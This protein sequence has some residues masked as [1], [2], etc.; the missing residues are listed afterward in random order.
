MAGEIT[1]LEGVVGDGRLDRALADALPDISRA[2]I[3][4]LAV[5][6]YLE[7][8]D[9][10]IA[11][12]SSKRYAG[13]KFTLRIPPARPDRAVAEDIAIEIV[14]ED[15]DLIIV[16]KPAGMVVH[17]SAG[18][19]SG[20]LVNALLHHCSGQ[21]SGIGG[22]AR[23]GI[24]HRIDRD[25]S[26]L[27]V[28]AKTD[29]A[30]AGLTKLFA[31]HDIERKYLAITRGIPAPPTGR[32]ETHIG[33]SPYDRKKM[34]VVAAP[35]GKHAV[36]HYRMIEP[37]KNAALIE[38]A[39]E[40]GRTHQIRVHLTHMKHPLIGDP[41]YG[42]RQNSIQIGPN[43]SKFARQALHAAILGFIHPVSGKKIRFESN[44]SGDMQELLSK[45]RV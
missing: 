33:R 21:L 17:P 4:A 34:A 14:Y 31:A 1:I 41:V 39:L 32:I 28:A 10:K 19:S 45:L 2:R 13:Q 7:I 42:S 35:D 29:L 26:G 6:G 43:Q 18:H 5:E 15:N 44:L 25:T 38:C 37:L 23:P 24:V 8:G 22:V 9:K 16:D 30:H 27:I 11:Q 12:L 20:T 40:T 36:T 3:K